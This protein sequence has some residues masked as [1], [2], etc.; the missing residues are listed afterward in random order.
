MAA[1]A[2]IGAAVAQVTTAVVEAIVF[3]KSHAVAACA[4]AAPDVGH[5]QAKPVGLVKAKAF[6]GTLAKRD[7]PVL[8]SGWRMCPSA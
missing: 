1:C 8:T 5:K 2:L 6:A 3:L 4:L 7:R